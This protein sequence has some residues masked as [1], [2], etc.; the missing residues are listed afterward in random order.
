M[1]FGVKSSLK[2]KPSDGFSYKF[3][4]IFKEKIKPILF[5]KTEEEGTLPSTF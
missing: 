4:Q 1:E 5:Q 2:N 3:Y